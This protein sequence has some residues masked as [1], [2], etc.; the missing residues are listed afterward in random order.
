MARSLSYHSQSAVDA[1]SH[2]DTDLD[3]RVRGELLEVLADRETPVTIDELVDH[4][5]EAEFGSDG[6]E[7]EDDLAAWSAI[8]ERLYRVDLPSLDAEGALAFDPVRGLVDAAAR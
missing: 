1:A 5:A 2:D 7:D 4:F 8:H 6:V 3:A